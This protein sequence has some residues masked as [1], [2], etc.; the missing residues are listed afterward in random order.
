MGGTL[1]S[2]NSQWLGVSSFEKLHYKSCRK[3]PS[4]CLTIFHFQQKTKGTKRSELLTFFLLF[5][6]INLSCLKEQ[7]G[8]TWRFGRGKNEQSVIHFALENFCKVTFDDVSDS[9]FF[10][11]KEGRTLLMLYIEQ[12][13]IAQNGFCCN[14]FF[15]Y[16]ATRGSLEEK[17]AL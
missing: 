4:S 2:N 1:Q 13:S 3:C 7:K 11:T 16:H 5:D 17:Q 10:G 12:S 14:N 8:K 15:N 6:N 9:S